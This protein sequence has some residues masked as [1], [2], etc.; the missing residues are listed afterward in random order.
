MIIE[1]L[2]L[3]LGALGTQFQRNPLIK[4]SLCLKRALVFSTAE[5]RLVSF[6]FTVLI[7]S[8]NFSFE[9]LTDFVK[10]LS[11]GYLNSRSSSAVISDHF[12]Y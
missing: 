4:L 12:H 11:E 9:D 2:H 10:V 8:A 5:Q 3:I 6:W 1:I 7:L